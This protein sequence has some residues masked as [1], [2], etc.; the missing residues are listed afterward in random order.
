MLWN[1]DTLVNM[2]GMTFTLD[3]TLYYLVSMEGQLET[4]YF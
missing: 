2:Y 3:T 1:K 4:G